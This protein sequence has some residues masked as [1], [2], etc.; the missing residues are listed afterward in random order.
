MEVPEISIS[1]EHRGFSDEQ[2]CLAKEETPLQ[3]SKILIMGEFLSKAQQPAVKDA[4]LTGGKAPEAEVL[5][6]KAQGGQGTKLALHS[7][8]LGD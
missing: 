8:P 1:D 5:W 6:L 3:E 7:E 4:S 2:S